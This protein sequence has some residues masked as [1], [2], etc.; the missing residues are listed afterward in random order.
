VILCEACKKLGKPG[1][2]R[3]KDEHDAQKLPW[4]ETHQVTEVDDTG[5]IPAGWFVFCPHCGHEAVDLDTLE[6]REV[7]GERRM[8]TD[9]VRHAVVAT[10]PD[11]ASLLQCSNCQKRYTF[12]PAWSFQTRKA[13]TAEPGETL[14]LVRKEPY[15]LHPVKKFLAFRSRTSA[16]SAL[17]VEQKEALMERG[18]E[19]GPNG[20]MYPILHRSRGSLSL[21]AAVAKENEYADM[22]AVI[23][24]QLYEAIMKG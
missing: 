9:K 16:L 10:M 21:D 13:V 20:Q 6:L 4:I 17:A 1:S 14:F 18:Y 24:E 5:A 11:G 12:D 23:Q 8:T 2:Y 19:E 22:D 15:D 3:T 7:N